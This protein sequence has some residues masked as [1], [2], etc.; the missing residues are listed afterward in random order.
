MEAEFIFFAFSSQY[1]SD[2]SAALTAPSQ[3]RNTYHFYSLS[4][5]YSKIKK[6][7][8]QFIV[9]LPR[10]APFHVTVSFTRRRRKADDGDAISPSVQDLKLHETEYFDCSTLYLIETS[11]SVSQANIALLFPSPR[12]CC[13]CRSCRNPARVGRSPLDRADAPDFNLVLHLSVVPRGR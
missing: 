2:L 3:S 9:A 7:Q 12:G 6:K 1:N 5:F 10:V 4:K 8:I 11:L 13:R